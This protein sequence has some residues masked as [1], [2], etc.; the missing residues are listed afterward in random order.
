MEKMGKR[1]SFIQHHRYAY[2]GQPINCYD[3]QNETRLMNGYRY[4]MSVTI[5]REYSGDGMIKEAGTPFLYTL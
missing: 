4:Q 2:I 5:A 3:A 1:E